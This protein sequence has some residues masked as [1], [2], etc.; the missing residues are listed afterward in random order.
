MNFLTGLLLSTDWKSYNN[1]SILGI[2][3]CLTKIVYYI[4][5]KVPIN[6]PE[7]LEIIIDVIM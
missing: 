2:V 5:V 6:I 1:D 3:D 4:L 7:L